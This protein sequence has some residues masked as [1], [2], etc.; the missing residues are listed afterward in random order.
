MERDASNFLRMTFKAER[1]NLGAVRN[2][3][4][5]F[6]AQLDF[7]LSEL[8][9]IKLAVSEAVTNAIVHAYPGGG[10]TVT[11]EARLV[12]GRLEVEVRDEGVGIADVTQARQPSFSTHPDRLGMGFA[13]MEAFVDELEVDSTPGRGTRVRLVKRP[14]RGQGAGLVTSTRGQDE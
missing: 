9:E 3:V 7:T 13:F 4:A 12:E 2:A 10:G 5:A 14:Q 6:A 11:V 8:E 1:G